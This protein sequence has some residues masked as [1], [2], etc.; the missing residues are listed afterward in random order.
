M[1]AFSSGILALRLAW[2]ILLIATG[3]SGAEEA[4]PRAL[5]GHTG[6]IPY[7][8]FLPD[9]ATLLSGAEDRTIRLWDVETGKEKLVWEKASAA[10]VVSSTTLISLTRDGAR[11][12]RAGAAPGTMEIWDVARAA[13]IQSF[14]AHDAPIDFFAVSRDDQ[15]LATVSGGELKIWTLVDGRAWGQLA[16]PHAGR[17]TLAALSSNGKLVAVATAD[18]VL[19]VCDARTGLAITQFE[20]P[21]VLRFRAIKFSLDNRLLLSAADS[22]KLNLQLWDVAMPRAIVSISTGDPVI[23][24]VAFSPDGRYIVSAGQR[25]R[26]WDS[27]SLR[28]WG[29]LAADAAPIVS[30]GFSPDGRTLATSD[31]DQVIKLWD[32]S[33]VAPM[34]LATPV[35]RDD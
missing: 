30:M 15:V 3:A 25:V 26:I 33:V 10:S 20:V 35:S 8:A 7:I 21:P 29:S 13:R 11:L 1:R 31:G 27:K 18:N 5:V 4:A 2:L 14:H 16:A 32:F 34:M 6:A 19:A 23:N 17:F 22:L 12:I 24:A 28:E 9:A